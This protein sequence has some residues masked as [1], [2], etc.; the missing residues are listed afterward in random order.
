MRRPQR[1]ANERCEDKAPHTRY[2]ATAN[3]LGTSRE[4]AALAC[5]VP[6]RQVSALWKA[7]GKRRIPGID[8]PRKACQAV[9]TVMFIYSSR[10]P[11]SFLNG[12]LSSSSAQWH[13]WAVGSRASCAIRSS[14]VRHYDLV[15]VVQVT[16]TCVSLV[17]PLVCLNW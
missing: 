5:V 1:H 8:L 14:R 3:A 10:C 4:I 15:Q 16:V 12:F 13:D 7:S 6:A 11:F 17:G 2:S 9:A